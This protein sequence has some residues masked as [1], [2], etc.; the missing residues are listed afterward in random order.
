[1]TT[2]NMRIQGNYIGWDF[3]NIWNPP[4]GVSYPTLQACLAPA[5]FTRVTPPAI[6]DVIPG[7]IP[8]V[9]RELPYIEVAPPLA[10]FALYRPGLMPSY[11]SDA[12][13]VFFVVKE[14]VVAPTVIPL[15]QPPP[16][17]VAPPYVPK[18]TRN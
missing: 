13:D 6:V 9:G 15:I 10:T 14:E 16:P 1:M 7:V 3:A 5:T 8:G 18:P 4:T 2:S 12:G 11:A 17:Y